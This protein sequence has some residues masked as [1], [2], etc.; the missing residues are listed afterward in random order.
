MAPVDVGERFGSLKHGAV[1]TGGAFACLRS[2][3]APL[4]ACG[5]G[6]LPLGLRGYRLVFTS[7]F[8]QRLPVIWRLPPGKRLIVSM[9]LFEQPPQRAVEVSYVRFKISSSGSIVGS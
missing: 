6:R 3:A 2:R 1:R 5:R 7:P 9:Q 4:R 8:S